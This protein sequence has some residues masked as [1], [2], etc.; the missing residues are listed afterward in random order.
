M[1]SKLRDERLQ[2][3]KSRVG[4]FLSFHDDH[5]MGASSIG[6]RTLERM[7]SRAPRRTVKRR[8]VAFSFPLC[9]R[10]ANR[11]SVWLE[12]GAS[13]LNS[14]APA[15][16]RVDVGPSIGTAGTTECGSDGV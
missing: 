16:C 1:A 12:D 9:S 2:L 4:S 7:G 8:T 3:I 6:F 5:V 14:E 15:F 11:V 10:V 13:R